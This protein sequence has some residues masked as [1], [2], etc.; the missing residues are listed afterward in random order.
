[1]HVGDGDDRDVSIDPDDM[2]VFDDT[3]GVVPMGILN[4]WSQKK[5]GPLRR[6]NSR[7]RL[8][9]YDE[10]EQAQTRLGQSRVMGVNLGVKGGVSPRNLPPVRF[11]T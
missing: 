4:Q 7:S 6:S 5:E 10:D 8:I 2:L 3:F 9:G 1:M 11:T